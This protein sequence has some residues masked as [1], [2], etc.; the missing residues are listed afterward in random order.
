MPSILQRATQ[1]TT[2]FEDKD[3]IELQ[4]INGAGRIQVS[5][6]SS[7][8][9]GIKPGTPDIEQAIAQ[10]DCVAFQGRDPETGRTSWQS[11]RP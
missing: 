2:N 9:N 6:T 7:L 1:S 5:S 8:K 4:F 11:P 10:Q 3:R